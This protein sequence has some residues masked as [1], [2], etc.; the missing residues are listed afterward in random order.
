MERDWKNVVGASFDGQ[1]AIE[2]QY[3]KEHIPA[4]VW[5]LVE[6]LTTMKD[7]WELLDDEFGKTSELVND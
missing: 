5:D 2:L 1:P 6:G 4:K 7:L 3:I